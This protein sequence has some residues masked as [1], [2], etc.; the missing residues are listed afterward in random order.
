MSRREDLAVIR[1]AL[2]GMDAAGGDRDGMPECPWCRSDGSYHTEGC[3]LVAARLA[4]ARLDRAS[5]REGR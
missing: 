5:R 4:L 3:A 1:S 2:D